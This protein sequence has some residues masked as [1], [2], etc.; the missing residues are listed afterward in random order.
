MSLHQHLRD[1]I[2]EAILEEHDVK[3]PETTRPKIDD[4]TKDMVVNR[5][6]FAV[7]IVFVLFVV[8]S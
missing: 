2:I 5:L 6:L 3:V 7:I 1:E 8:L 4:G